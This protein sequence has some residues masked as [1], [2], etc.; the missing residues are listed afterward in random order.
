[1]T[2]YSQDVLE[3][4]RQGNDIIEVISQ[5]VQLRQKGGNFMG[6]CPFHNEKSPSFSVSPQKQLFHCFGCGAG[7]N[8][9][10]FIMKIENFG[11]VDA[12]KFLADRINYT[13]PELSASPSTSTAEKN[14]MHDIYKQAARFYYDTLQEPVGRQ[15]ATYLDGRRIATAV[16]RKFG[17]G[18]SPGR[19]VLKDFL[20]DKGHDEKIL[21]RAG[22]VMEGKNGWYDR[23]RDRLMF[24]IFDVTGKV[25]GFG[26]RIIGD[27][28]PKYLNSP[29]SP[30]FDKSRTLYG[31][32][33]AR[34]AKTNKLILVEGY[35]DVIALYQQGI[36]NTVAAL[37]TA[38]T[39]NHARILKR[40]CKE[41][42][43]LFD[44]DEAGVRATLRAIP[45]LYSAGLAVRV[46]TLP[47]AKDP[48]EY[49]SRFGPQSL[50]AQ[51]DRSLDFVDFQ[52]QTALQK[53]DLAVTT[54]RI[55]FLKEA[56]EII[57]KLDSSIEREAYLRDLSTK[58]Q[59]DQGAVKEEIDKQ[60]GGEDRFD[61]VVNVRRPR[62][63]APSKAHNDA[64]HHILYSMAANAVLYDK[65]T[66]HLAPNELAEPLYIKLYNAIAAARQRG[67]EVMPADIITALEDPADQEKAAAAFSN[68][69]EYD[70]T[71]QQYAALAQQIWLVKMAGYD[72][73]IAAGPD[74]KRLNELFFA[75]NQLKNSRI[76]L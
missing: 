38:L 17:L 1:M 62:A 4:L 34:L 64:I 5:Y 70:S 41:V 31:L 71:D 2:G 24:P 23:F 10:S 21:E 45:H 49:L 69:T 39:A 3:D 7:G 48:D 60:Q 75:K 67:R 36:T 22:L 57:G 55:A 6:L 65:I 11:F 40:Y 37:G 63:A 8:V 53:Y 18:Y 30:I 61:F 12:M 13:M 42:I 51:L 56:A 14:Q 19:S 47:D 66:A 52:V 54:Q 29:E 58:Y 72:M 28:Q 43:I 73:E 35:M 20:T 27:G 9:F 74:D 59:I 44:E 68:I 46:A 15:A 26:G 50:L 16:R 25:T 33:Y 32:N 76:L